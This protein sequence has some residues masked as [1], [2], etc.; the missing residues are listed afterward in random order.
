MFSLC[1]PCSF[2][3]LLLLLFVR[4][5]KQT[6]LLAIVESW[7]HKVQ[8][9]F[10]KAQMKVYGIF[11]IERTR[12]WGDNER[13]S[14][15]WGRKKIRGWRIHKIRSSGKLNHLT[16]ECLKQE[17]KT[18][19]LLLYAFQTLQTRFKSEKLLS[20]NV[21]GKLAREISTQARTTY[22]RIL[23]RFLQDFIRIS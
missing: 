21:K 5:S 19:I 8:K 18:D 9:R 3:L 13:S 12:S 7:G 17:N 23:L 16:V 6:L 2:S 11:W 22:E 4:A 10:I 20:F 1:F 14:V 15:F